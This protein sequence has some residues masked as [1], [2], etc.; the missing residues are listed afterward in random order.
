MICLL[1][2]ALGC[3][4]LKEDEHCG[5][6]SKEGV[7]IRVLEGICVFKNIRAPQVGIY[8][9]KTGKKR[10]P[11][12]QAKMEARANAATNAPVEKAAPK[13]AEKTAEA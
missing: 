4:G 7:E 6:F 3:K 1:G 10:N 8:A 11:L 2:K 5:V 13:P 12:K 9:P